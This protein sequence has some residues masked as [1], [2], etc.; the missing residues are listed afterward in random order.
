MKEIDEKKIDP[1]IKIPFDINFF[2]QKKLWLAPLAG[3]TD[4][5]FRY[6]AKQCGVDVLVSEMVSADGVKKNFD[7]FAHEVKFSDIERP[8][9]I[10]LFGDNPAVMA[11]AALLLSKL[12]P[13]FFDINMGCPVKKVVKRYAG[14]A[15]MMKPE[16]S[17]EIIKEVCKVLNDVNIPLTVKIRAGWDFDSINAVPFAQMVESAGA[18]AI[19]V[20]PRT[21][22][23]FFTGV[24]NW[25]I[26]T[27]VK[28][29]V[30]I[31]VIGNGDIHNK[32]EALR[33]YNET[34]CDSVMIGRGALGKPWVFEEI[35][36]RSSA[37][38]ENRKLQIIHKHIDLV[39]EHYQDP[40]ALI[41]MRA[42]FAYYT[43]G[44]INGSK[45]RQ[46]IFAS[47]DP[48]EIKITMEKLIL[49]VL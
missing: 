9:G 43:K 1:N 23:Q 2:T 16:L 31:P 8:Y 46:I 7:R 10:Q 41:P 40:R 26:I 15:L 34:G 4:A 36:G 19:I 13:D 42:H 33:M 14:S 11:K 6:I 39:L 27:Q 28:E 3:Y 20:H 22:S 5:P 17:E 18:S 45:A 24:S 44:Y 35:K 21:R 38:I 12:K 25:A 32:E 29:A 48:E 30:Q 37:E 49:G 47:I